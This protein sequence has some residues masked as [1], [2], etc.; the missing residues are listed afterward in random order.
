MIK[1]IVIRDVASYDHEGCT[2]DDLAKVNIIY[3]GN[4]TGKTTLSRVVENG[5][6]KDKFPN[7]KIESDGEP[8]RFLVYNK[9]TKAFLLHQEQVKGVFTLVNVP[10]E[11]E[12]ELNRLRPLKQELIKKVYGNISND[13]EWYGNRV[14]LESVDDRLRELES[15]RASI[16][17]FAERINK[18]LKYYGYTKE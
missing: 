16:N 9:D 18:I 2:F 7:C 4:G 6:M 1:K 13:D 11:E 10:E 17:P 5:Y 14:V 8:S 3:G 12:K 15:S